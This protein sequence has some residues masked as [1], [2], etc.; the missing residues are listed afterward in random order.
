M[1]QMAGLENY[2]Q[3]VLLNPDTGETLSSKLG[4]VATIDFLFIDHDKSLY[5]KD[6]QELEASGM[7]QRGTH[8][9]ADNVIFANIHDYRDYMCQQARK[10]IVKTRLEESFLEYSEPER[11]LATSIDG[12][13]DNR[14]E[15]LEM[16][17]DGIELSVYL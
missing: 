13:G 4:L 5:L 17:K 1:I 14:R 11:R 3:I 6:L 2:I 15:T 7:I 10:G 9:A 16:L 8:V 12:G